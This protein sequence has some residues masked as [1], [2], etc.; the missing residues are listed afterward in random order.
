[1]F[2]ERDG[3]LSP[4][5]VHHGVRHD[6]EDLEP[7]SDEEAVRMLAASRRTPDLSAF[8]GIEIAEEQ[9]IYGH[10]AQHAAKKAAEQEAKEAVAR[11]QGLKPWQ[12]KTIHL[13]DRAHAAI[14]RQV[15]RLK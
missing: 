6:I 2:V 12:T 9:D 14:E 3:T 15:V 11:M 5:Y 1:M 10:V 13:L 8:E 7:P 4:I